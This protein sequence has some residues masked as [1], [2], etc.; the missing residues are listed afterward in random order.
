MAELK[1]GDFAALITS[2]LEYQ[3]TRAERDKEPYM[4]VGRD[5]GDEMGWN[6]NI[7][8]GQKVYVDI[9]KK[10]RTQLINLIIVKTKVEQEFLGFQYSRAVNFCMIMDILAM[11]NLTLKCMG[12]MM[13]VKYSY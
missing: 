2:Q 6:E 12:Q 7:A 9:R 10:S 3:L 13:K 1:K 5:Y 4:Y 8:K 11:K